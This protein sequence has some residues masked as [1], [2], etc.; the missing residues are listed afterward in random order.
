ME[1]WSVADREEEEE[2]EEERESWVAEQER[3]SEMERVKREGRNW[4][5]VA[6]AQRRRRAERKSL[7]SAA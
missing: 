2:E 1:E 7:S 4:R 3:R 6:R 5:I